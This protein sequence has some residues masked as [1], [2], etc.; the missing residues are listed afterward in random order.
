MATQVASL[1]GILSL[2][3]SGFKK[4]L[5]SAD[6]EAKGFGDRLQSMGQSV[7]MVGASMTAFTAPFVAGMAVAA[8]HERAAG[9]G[10]CLL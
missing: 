9:G 1:F 2:D 8:Q 10:G 4:G 5:E 3:D 7:T 6:R